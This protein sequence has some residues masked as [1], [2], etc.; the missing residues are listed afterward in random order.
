MQKILV[1]TDFSPLA[2]YATNAAVQIARK[3]GA[4]V[5][6]LHV[7]EMP[8]ASFSI[9]GQTAN[10]SEFDLYTLKLIAKTKKDL[11]KVV[12][13]TTQDSDLK[14][15]TNL[16]VGNAYQAIAQVIADQEVDL[17]VMGSHGADGWEET[18]VG[19]NAEKVV[20][21]AN[22]PVLVIKGPFELDQA[23]SVI[24]AADFEEESTVIDQV[25]VFQNILGAK[26]HLVRINTP[27][28]FV[29]DHVGIQVLR[30]FAQKNGL[31]NYTVNIYN[32]RLEENGIMYFAEEMNAHVI[33][34]GT[35]GR[36]GM[37]HLLSGSI[38]EDV[39]NHAKRPVWTCRMR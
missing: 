30:D 21:R 5:I 37:Q 33:A 32:D 34:L 22:C 17:V 26:L 18:F 31:D 9:T 10:N 19:S 15:H 36:S 27:A 8:G 1:P 7:V 14:M 25:K 3:I 20:R 2:V 6:L 38:A 16:Q 4:E 29:S 39:V 23:K 35:H 28:N 24:F 13:N 11:I 12:A